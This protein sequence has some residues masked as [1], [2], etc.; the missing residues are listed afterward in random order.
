M[1]QSYVTASASPP[2]LD[3]LF[4]EDPDGKPITIRPNENQCGRVL[5]STYHAEGGEADALLAQE[6]AL[7]YILLEVGVGVGEQPPPR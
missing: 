4:P 5:F 6:K 2:P 3:R 1:R 7:L